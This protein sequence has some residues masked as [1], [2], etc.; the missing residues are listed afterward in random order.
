[1]VIVS[2][3]VCKFK[4]IANSRGSYHLADIVT[5]D[6]TLNQVHSI[7]VRETCCNLDSKNSTCMALSLI[8]AYIWLVHAFLLLQVVSACA[9]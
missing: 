7:F 5:S 2:V 4:D 9:Y 8:S 6:N 3:F 1:M